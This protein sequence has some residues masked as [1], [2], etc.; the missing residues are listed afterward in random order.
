MRLE[1]K[2]LANT[3][4]FLD[5]GQS[6][7]KPKMV[8]HETWFHHLLVAPLIPAEAE[9]GRAVCIGVQNTRVQS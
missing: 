9:H 4:T 8:A 1:G 7:Q 3:F 2:N 5:M 6:R